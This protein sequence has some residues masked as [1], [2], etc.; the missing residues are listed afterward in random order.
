M[1]SIFSLNFY[2]NFISMNRYYQYYCNNIHLHAMHVSNIFNFIKSVESFDITFEYSKSNSRVYKY[3]YGHCLLYE[4][5]MKKGRNYNS[6]FASYYTATI[7][8]P[9]NLISPKCFDSNFG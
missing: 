9:K 2:D 5:K 8:S 3:F 1:K 7:I 4:C 6:D